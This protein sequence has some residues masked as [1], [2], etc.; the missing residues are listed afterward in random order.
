MNPAILFPTFKLF[1]FEPLFFSI[2]VK[3]VYMYRNLDFKEF[4]YTV[5]FFQVQLKNRRKHLKI[6]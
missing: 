6:S 1:R 5:H 2:S 4:M 3:L